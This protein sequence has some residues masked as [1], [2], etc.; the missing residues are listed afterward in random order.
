[1]NNYRWI[2]FSAFSLL[3]VLVLSVFVNENIQ[4][5]KSM[6]RVSQ[7]R[8]YLTKLEGR[9]INISQINKDLGTDLDPI[10]GVGDETSVGITKSRSHYLMGSSE[11]KVTLACKNGFLKNSTVESVLHGF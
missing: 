7:S 10:T 5:S 11:T 6:A 3:V 4:Y 1:M 2:L 8:I 9:E